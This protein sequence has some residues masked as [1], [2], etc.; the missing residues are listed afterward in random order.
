M[1]MDIMSAQMMAAAQRILLSQN[2]PE[3]Q[4]N[5]FDQTP[6]INKDENK[7]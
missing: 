3:E 4:N 2:S 1:M 6:N 7:T 5:L